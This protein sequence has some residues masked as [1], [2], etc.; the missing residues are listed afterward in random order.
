MR[1][2]NLTPKPK[3]KALKLKGKVQEPE[4]STALA[5]STAAPENAENPVILEVLINSVHNFVFMF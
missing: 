2:G 4:E 1:M 3:K 5:A